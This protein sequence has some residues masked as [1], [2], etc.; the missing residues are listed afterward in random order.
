MAAC[1][2]PR[3]PTEE[4]ADEV[5]MDLE[6]AS[7]MPPTS[8]PP[9][10]SVLTEAIS[11]GYWE[12][13]GCKKSKCWSAKKIAPRSLY[14]GLPYTHTCHRGSAGTTTTR[15]EKRRQRAR[16]SVSPLQAPGTA[17]AWTKAFQSSTGVPL[18]PGLP[19]ASQA[20][21]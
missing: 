16:S 13:W 17:T 6:P 1:E 10:E 3:G 15:I 8:H 9:L 20:G 12:P 21:S 7:L 19:S 11:C 4:A 18:G 5:A 14:L 2:M